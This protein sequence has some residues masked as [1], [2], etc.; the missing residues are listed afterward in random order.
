M[1]QNLLKT[2]VPLGTLLLLSGCIDNK[3]DL[4]DIDKTTQIN[5]NDLVV[6]V[7]IDAIELSEII[8]IDDDSK[9]KIVDL[10]GTEVYAVTESG[11]FSSDPIE[12]DGFESNDIHIDPTVA[13][14]DLA[15]TRAA[16]VNTYN[17]GQFDP[18][19]INI[20][21]SD[22]DESII[23]ID[24][25]R[26]E[27][28]KIEM[29]FEATGFDNNTDLLFKT[30]SFKFLKGLTLQNLPSNYAYDPDGLLT[31]S[32]VPCRRVVK[33]GTAIHE[34]VVSV[35]A[36]AVD[37]SK[38]GTKLIDHRFEYI[39]TV[40]LESAVM[41][42]TINY[43][44]TAPQLPASVEFDV[45]TTAENLKATHFSG[46][47]EYKLEGDALE[48][49]PVNLD[50][51]PDFLNNDETN[52]LLANPQIYLNMN[53]PLAPYQLGFTTGLELASIRDG[54][55]TDFNLD[56]GQLVKVGTN[57][58]VDGPYNYVLSPS[59]PEQKLPGYT[60]NLQ[61]VGFASLSNVLS[62]DGLPQQIEIHLV[63]PGL[64]RQKVTDF[65]LFNTIPGIEG[66]YDF[67][68]PLALKTG[69]NGAVIIYR[70]SDTGW[71]DDDLDKLT[72]KTLNLEA[73]AFS[74]LPIGAELNVWP[75]DK[76][77]NK[78]QGVQVTPAIVAPNSKGEPVSITV[79]GDIKDLDGVT[80]EAKVHAGSENPLSPQ[81]TIRLENIK[82]KVSGYYLTDFE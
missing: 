18:Q 9:I 64:P 27:P 58:G 10:N 75:L 31:I 65:K 68:A 73:K 77:G 69:E 40:E 50:D 33:N 67:F 16:L 80:Y 48:I 53:N 61:H 28:M 74:D 62:G 78:I 60:A 82:A 37:F 66:K 24:A 38:T 57:H 51:I 49:D 21:A 76:N 7:N 32:N 59:M 19:T 17:L 3:Y 11:D 25:I 54:K 79:T 43:T 46:Q 56:N 81:Q 12:I 6:P 30:L 22:V 2:C 35:T 29:H 14:F 8:K 63:N 39:S 13:R 72:I 23:D 36:I 71:S 42:M 45:N 4:S 5:I 41:E 52:L 20:N 1:K 47:I 70:D 15:P 55:K 26:C 44:T 34:G